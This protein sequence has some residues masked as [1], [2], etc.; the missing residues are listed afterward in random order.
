MGNKLYTVDNLF[1]LNGMNSS[2]VDLIYLDPPFNSKRTYSAPI[3][4]KCAG[5]SFKDMWTW[6]DVNEG[7][8]EGLID[9]YPFLVQFI[10]S[11]KIIHSK[12]MMAYLT[13]MT[14]RIIEMHRVLKPTGSLYLHCDPTAS[15]Y[16]KVVL[17]RIFGAGRFMNEVVWERTTGRSNAR[18]YAR[19]H[20][21]VLYYSKSGKYTWNGYWTPLTDT[22]VNRDYRYEDDKG[23]YRTTRI[24]SP[25][26]NSGY[27]Y[28]FHGQMGPWRYP[29]KRLL[30]IEKEGLIWWPQK[31]G[32]MPYRKL[33]LDDN[34]GNAIRDVITGIYPQ[35]G[36]Q[37]TGYPTQKP[38][39]L[40]E[41]IIKAS[42]NEGDVVLDPFCGSGTTL[43]AADVM[44]R[45]WIGIDLNIDAAKDRLRQ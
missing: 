21:I 2:S 12:A 10:E 30:E 32:A 42:S 3:G 15:H 22:Q 23:K 27:R 9:N 19:V 24:D 35:R 4:S 41:R 34:K 20:D 29:E 11:V 26:K 43:V 31:E 40:L 37:R 28:S 33:Y 6:D 17:D 45:R 25:T 39:K 8:L 16:L 5:A 1:V 38:L 44:K 13:F 36:E 18:K 7:Y 14:Q